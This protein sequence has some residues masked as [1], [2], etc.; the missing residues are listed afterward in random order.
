MSTEARQGTAKVLPL[1]AEFPG[2]V[3]TSVSKPSSLTDD[4][5]GSTMAHSAHRDKAGAEV[6]NLV[7]SRWDLDG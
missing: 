4:I 6:R 5:L 3:K 1:S 7:A 2:P